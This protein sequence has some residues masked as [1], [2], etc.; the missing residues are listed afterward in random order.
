MM[1]LRMMEMT[2]TMMKEV[3][4]CDGGRDSE[5]DDDDDDGDDDDDDDDGDEGADDEE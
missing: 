4:D 3:T 5:C 1:L 2:M